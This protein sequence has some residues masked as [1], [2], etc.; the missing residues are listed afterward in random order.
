M[1]GNNGGCNYARCPYRKFPRRHCRWWRERWRERWWPELCVEWETPEFLINCKRNW[2]NWGNAFVCMFAQCLWRDQKQ[3]L[4]WT[5]F[6]NI[7]FYTTKYEINYF[8]RILCFVHARSRNRIRT[9][10][11]NFVDEFCNFWYSA[12]SSRQMPNAYLL[13][14]CDIIFQELTSQLWIWADFFLIHFVWAVRRVNTTL[15]MEFGIKRQHFTYVI[16]LG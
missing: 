10:F 1:V 4:P 6:V 5:A 16:V 9:R 8:H 12:F 7:M 11:M 14:N 13:N 2:I 15:V 3:L